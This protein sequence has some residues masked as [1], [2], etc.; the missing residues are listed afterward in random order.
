M[1]L[2]G[3][4]I[5]AQKSK[6]ARA[7]VSTILVLFIMSF[8]ENIEYLAYLYWPGLLIMGIAFKE[9]VYD[10]KKISSFN[11]IIQLFALDTIELEHETSFSLFQFTS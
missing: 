3:L 5:K 10:F 2:L 8:A 4:L 11:W 9:V 1:E 7:G 6:A